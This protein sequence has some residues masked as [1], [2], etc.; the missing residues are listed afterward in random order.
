LAL[1]IITQD[2]ASKDNVDINAD[3]GNVSDNE[4]TFNLSSTKS[5]IDEQNIFTLDIFDPKIG[6][7][8]MTKL[9]TSLQ[10]STIYLS[11]TTDEYT[12]K[13]KEYIINSSVNQQNHRGT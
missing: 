3:N 10:E 12:Y 4:N 2:Q 6:I 7:L 9:E 11:V 8:L 1:E 13:N 5:V